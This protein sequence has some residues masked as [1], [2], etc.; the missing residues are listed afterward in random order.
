MPRARA[1]G[2]L[3]DLISV[4][5]RLAI[6]RG[7][8]RAAQACASGRNNDITGL[9]L[10]H[11]FLRSGVPGSRHSNGLFKN[12]RRKFAKLADYSARRVRPAAPQSP[13]RFRSLQ[14]RGDENI[15]ALTQDFPKH[16]SRSHVESA[17][18]FEPVINEKTSSG[19]PAP[20]WIDH[21]ARD[22]NPPCARFSSLDQWRLC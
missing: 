4:I 13:W 7:C 9:S 16:N 5:P 22:P 6:S 10:Q 11:T 17:A 15:C 3:I 18:V 2:L 14:I 20:A 1:S 8:L 19:A 12:G 21:R